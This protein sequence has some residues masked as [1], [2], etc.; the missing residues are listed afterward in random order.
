M[1]ID[2]DNVIIIGTGLGGLLA[3]AFLAGGGRRVTFLETLD[4]IGGRFTHLDYQGF[5]VPTGAFHTLPGGGHGP[6][7]ACLRRL[8][9][10]L[11]VVEPD[12]AFLVVAGEKR[13]PIYLPPFH[14]RNAGLRRSLEIRSRWRIMLRMLGCGVDSLLGREH[15]VDGLLRG[16]SPTDLPLRLLDHLTRFSFCV[17]S[18][19]A[20]VNYVLRSLRLI[21]GGT[22]EGF[23]RGGNRALVTSLLDYALA[24]GAVPRTRTP[25]ARILVEGGRAIGIET[26]AGER[27]R[28]GTIVSNAGARGT[29]ALLG[30]H[31]PA[32]FTA[33]VRRMKPACGASHAIR[34]R[35]RLH[36]HNGIELPLDLDHVAGI[37]PV[38]NSCPE[39]CPP[40]WH[41]SLAYQALDRALPIKPQVEAA[42]RELSAYFG[43]E[44]EVFNTATYWR[45]YPA[46]ALAPCLG[47]TGNNR[48]APTVPGIAGL[49]LAGEDV[50]GYGFAAEVIGDSSRRLWRLLERGGAA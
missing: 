37:A 39:L 32:S 28:A 29:A 46:G 38:S 14:N 50:S 35:A 21:S 26:E 3:G 48:F 33:R 9:I 49:Y 24:R 42:R 30:G 13:V 16:L 41:Y 4:I 44:A 5:A 18:R 40:G 27:L 23:L 12:P 34:S 31:A 10:P 47:Q 15:A 8:G 2:R 11:D 1:S 22:G 7:A 20:P 36:E 6:V 17:P 43:P 45:E 25:V 19:E